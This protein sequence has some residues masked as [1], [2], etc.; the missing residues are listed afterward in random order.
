MMIPLLALSLGMDAFAVSI[1]CGMSPGFRRR[2][3]LWLGIYFGGFQALM[4]LL[5]AFL[6]HSF[7]QYVAQAGGWIA[8]GL[9]A[10]IGGNMV[11]GALKGDRK[12]DEITALSH[13]RLFVLAIA[14]SIDAFAAGVSLALLTVNLVVACTV[15]GGVAFVLSV[16]GGLFGKRVGEA[17]HKR[18]ELVG[19]I[20]LIALGIRSLF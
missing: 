16:S 4:T 17:F 5:G 1:S 6:G 13:K 19:G 3:A 2:S 11:W 20:V 18:A 10:L 14:T 12:P 9:L 7:H 15:I 8:F